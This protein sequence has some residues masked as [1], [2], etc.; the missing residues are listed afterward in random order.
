MAKQ[1]IMTTFLLSLASLALVATAT[2]YDH[3][4]D[5][6]KR[7]VRRVVVVGDDGE[8][9]TLTLDGGKL[10]VKAVSDG[11]VEIHEIDIA[12]I[13]VMVDEILGDVLGGLEDVFGEMAENNIEVR[14]ED[15]NRLVISGDGHTTTLDVEEM[16][17][18][19]H[20]TLEDVFTELEAEFGDIGGA[21]F[22]EHAHERHERHERH[23]APSWQDDDRDDA[24]GEAE[25]LREEIAQMRRE[26]RKLRDEIKRA[27]RSGGR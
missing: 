6:E 26:I 11:D 18:E 23:E 2:A 7:D 22:G 5:H 13:G 25:A 3:D 9:A 4:S 19:L 1:R 17:E 21:H 14:C 27:G 8:E 24:E 20:E 15:E 16:M 10:R 12:E